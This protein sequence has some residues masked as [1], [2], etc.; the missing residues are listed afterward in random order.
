M[1]TRDS[2]RGK[3]DYIDAQLRT[4]R[5]KP[6]TRRERE[7]LNTILA[8]HTTYIEIG[9]ALTISH[10]TVR[11]HVWRLLAKTGAVNMAEL[12]LMAL[13]H[14]PCPIDFRGIVW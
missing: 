8:G 2:T 14:K 6:L 10:G 1:T 13:G 12:V 3:A 4:L 11:S 5:G 9:R 7:V